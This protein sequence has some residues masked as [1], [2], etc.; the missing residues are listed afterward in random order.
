[1]GRMEGRVAFVTGAA[2]G[3]GRSHAIR[4]AQEG[5]AIV[6]VD[7]CDQIAAVP[8]PM[9]TRADL[10]ETVNLVEKDGGSIL[11]ITADV[12]DESALRAAFASGVQQFG[13]VDTVLANAG[14]ILTRRDEPDRKT[15]WEVGIG[16]MLTG[17]WNTIQVAYPHMIEYGQGGAIVVTSSMAGLRA[18][19]DGTAGSDAYTVAK[20]GVTGLIRSY[21]QFLAP[22]NIRVTG[23]APTGVS[24]PMI[25][26]NPALFEAIE[27]NDNL[28]KSMQNALP[29]PMI[30][31][32]DVSEAILYMV[33]DSGRYVTGITV[34]I[35]A[36][37]G[38]A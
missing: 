14:V 32:I 27:A 24:T 3:Q 26:E 19:T 6:A 13:H 7:I 4:L 8:Y 2:R 21:A 16:V 12:R 17:V 36:G 10:D 30:E 29:V 37:M 9:S 31:P 20:I 38:V 23:V 35:D 18:L 34:P 25:T 22:H 15:A 28:A 5:A 11:A 33:A 1:M